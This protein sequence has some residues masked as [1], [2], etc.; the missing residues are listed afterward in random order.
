MNESE[1]SCLATLE[2]NRQHK[3]KNRN[4]KKEA[5]DQVTRRKN[6]SKAVI[7]GPIFICSCCARMLFENG[8][9]KITRKFKEAE[10]IKNPS[11]YSSCIAE[12][13]LVKI[14]FDGSTD[15]TGHYIC[16][17]CKTAMKSGKKPSMAVTNGLQLVEI[18]EGSDLTELE[19]NL[20]AQHINFQ[21]IYCLPNSRWA[22]T[23]KQMIS[24]PVAPE[25]VLNTVQQLP[26]LPRDAGL[27][28]VQLKR[29]LSYEGCHKKEFI[30]PNKVLGTLHHLKNSGHPDYQF[31]DDMPDYKRRF[32]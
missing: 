1:E 30:D 15:K 8:V 18:L 13:I 24:V 23:K 14:I 21:Y 7:F 29:K 4:M 26:R 31:F 6:F 10:N 11:F 9:T 16:H 12:E 2:K 19:N 25:S 27:F 5:V 20:I 28:P 3:E 22:A 32:M 17:T